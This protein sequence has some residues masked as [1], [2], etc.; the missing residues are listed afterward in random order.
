MLDL[1]CS[2][3]WN[4]ELLFRTRNEQGSNIFLV[5]HFISMMFR[6]R[7]LRKSD[8][9]HFIFMMF[10]IRELRKSDVSLEVEYFKSLTN[11]ICCY[12]SIPLSYKTQVFM[13]LVVICSER[14]CRGLS[15]GIQ[16]LSWKDYQMLYSMI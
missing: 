2:C 12:T 8:V 3:S 15:L 9:D 4:G 1:C 7:E 10:R 6:I 14:R 5:D 11:E 16:N 13:S